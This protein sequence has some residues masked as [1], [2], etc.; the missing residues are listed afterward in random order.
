[1]HSP[2]YE[3]H[4]KGADEGL[5]CVKTRNSPMMILDDRTARMSDIESRFYSIRQMLRRLSGLEVSVLDQLLLVLL[6]GL[7]LVL[8]SIRL[9]VLS[10][11][12]FNNESLLYLFVRKWIPGPQQATFE[13]QP[14]MCRAMPKYWRQMRT[15]WPTNHSWHHRN[16]KQGR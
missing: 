9:I 14:D 12:R 1:M 3:N 7:G 8:H 16:L 2:F 5:K 6:V 4:I 10:I 11:L 13:S 15:I